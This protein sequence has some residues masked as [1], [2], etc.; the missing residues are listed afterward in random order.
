MVA[1]SLT[2][3]LG[4]S[5]EHVAFRLFELIYDKEKGAYAE[6]KTPG[7]IDRKWILETYALCLVTVRK[8]EQPPNWAG[9]AAA[10][11]SR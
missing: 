4:E 7:P 2:T 10:L 1:F 5:A 8:P 3:E 11:Q 9:L 6:Q